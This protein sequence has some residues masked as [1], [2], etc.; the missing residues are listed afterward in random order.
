MDMEYFGIHELLKNKK[1]ILILGPCSLIQTVKGV[2][3]EMFKTGVLF[4]NR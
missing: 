4:R 1:I 2:S 3:R